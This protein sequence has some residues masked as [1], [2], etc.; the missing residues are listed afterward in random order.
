MLL[1]PMQAPLQSRICVVIGRTRHTA[2]GVAV[3]R[4]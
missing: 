2:M 4:T 1:R 3:E